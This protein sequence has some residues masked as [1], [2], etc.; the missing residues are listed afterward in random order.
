MPNV[1]DVITRGVETMF[2]LGYEFVVLVG[3]CCKYTY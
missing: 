1:S 3:M 2:K